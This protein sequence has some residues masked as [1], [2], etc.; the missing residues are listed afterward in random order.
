MG[1][2]DRLDTALN[3]TELNEKRPMTKIIVC[4]FGFGNNHAGEITITLTRLSMLVSD[5][6]NLCVIQVTSGVASVWSLY[7]VIIMLLFENCSIH[8]M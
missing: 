1:F 6:Y 3:V 7:I 8:C 5:L 2:P 4:V